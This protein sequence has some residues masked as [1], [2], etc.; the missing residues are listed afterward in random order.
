MV[1]PMKNMLA[2][3]RLITLNIDRADK[4]RFDRL[5]SMKEIE[6]NQELSQAGF[7]KIVLTIMETDK[8]GKNESKI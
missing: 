4:L 1:K 2:E 7:F 8:E 5:K 3:N 6:I